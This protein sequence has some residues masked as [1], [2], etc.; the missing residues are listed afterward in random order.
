MEIVRTAVVVV[1]V[2]FGDEGTKNGWIGRLERLKGFFWF[3]VWWVFGYRE[4]VEKILERKLWC[5]L[6]EKESM[7]KEL[8]Y[9]WQILGGLI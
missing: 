3:V 2:V 4:S 6:I 5:F 8:K 1:V 7:G 9:K